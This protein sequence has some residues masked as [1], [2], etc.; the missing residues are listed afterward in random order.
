MELTERQKQ[1]IAEELTPVD[2]ET[3]DQWL[4]DGS[5][6]LKTIFVDGQYYRRGE[7]EG[8]ARGVTWDV[9][10]EEKHRL[11]REEK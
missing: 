7:A 3:L 6:E 8:I 1:A 2:H 11:E 9:E 10:D 5:V 4:I